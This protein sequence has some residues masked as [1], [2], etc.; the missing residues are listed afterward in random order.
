MQS[1]IISTILLISSNFAFSQLQEHNWIIVPE[2]E[3]QNVPVKIEYLQIKR[4]V[5]FEDERFRKNGNRKKLVNFEKEYDEKG[6]LTSF[7]RIDKNGKKHLMFS[8]VYDS[9]KKTETIKTFHHKTGK[10]L[11]QVYNERSAKNAVYFKRDKRS[12]RKN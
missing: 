10:L 8:F 9:L 2:Y 7:N 11:E 12:E 5:S 6:R 1:I 4:T 3:A